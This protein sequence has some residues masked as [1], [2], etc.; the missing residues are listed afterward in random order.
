MKITEVKPHSPA[1]EAGIQAGDELLAVNGSPVGDQL[2]FLFHSADDEVILHIRRGKR[3][4]EAELPGFGVDYGLTFE[5]MDLMS[6]GNRCVFCFIDQ[7]PRGMRKTIYFKD[8]DYRLSFLHGAYVTLTALRERDFRRIISQRLSPLYVSVHATDPEVRRAILNIRRD[9]H[10]MEKIDRLTGEG[11]ILHTQIVVCPGLNNGEILARSI[12]DLGIRHPG[13]QSV[14]VVPVGLTEHRTGLFPLRPVDAVH[15]RST[16][17]LVD[18]LR[19]EYRKET[20]AGFVYCS[21]EWYIRAGMDIPEAEYYDEFPQIE[22]GVGMVRDFL[23]AAGS[24]ETRENPPRF[25]G[26]IALVTGVSMARYIDDFARRLAA[27]I[28]REVRAVA[29][30]NRFFGASVTVSGLLT[31]ADIIRA[32]EG[33]GPDETIVLP[34]NCLNSDGLFLDD[35]TPDDIARTFGAHVVQGGYD[36]VATFFDDGEDGES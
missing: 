26:K 22:N 19:K 14:A 31:G 7:N 13:V 8:E 1:A 24:L 23:D 9:D 15:A 34:P 33:T 35:L 5:A 4:F 29:V 32:L 20:G 17:S 21:D 28:G 3:Q 25:S 36:P 27:H 6:C 10:L 11:I 18:R 2:D 30:P 12:R 16:I